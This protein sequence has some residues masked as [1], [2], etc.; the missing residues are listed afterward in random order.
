MSAIR[1]A[2]TH[3]PRTRGGRLETLRLAHENGC[4][5]NHTIYQVAVDARGPNRGAV[6]VILA[7]NGCPQTRQPT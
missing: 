3:K 7:A 2:P 6:L 5:W 4:H 1:T